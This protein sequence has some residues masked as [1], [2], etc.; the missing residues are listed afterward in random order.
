MRSSSW[1]A[2]G[3]GNILRRL[4]LQLRN[5]SGLSSSKPAPVSRLARWLLVTMLPVAVA[6][7]VVAPVVLL[8]LQ[9]LD[10]TVD[11]WTQLWNTTLPSMI[12][13]TFFLMVGVGLITFVIGSGLAWLLTVYRFPGHQIFD[14]ALVLPLAVP[15]YVMG[16][17]YMAT[18]DFAGPVQTTLRAWLGPD[19]VF[20]NIRSGGG[21]IL[22]MGLTLYPYVY[23]LARTAFREQ[24]RSTF[25]AARAMGYSRT[26]TFLKLV[27]PLA[28][29]SLVAGV[30]LAVLEA[31]TDFAT[32]RFFNFPTISEGVV[33]VWQGMMNRDA[34]IE[35]AAVFLLFALVLVMLE[36]ALRGRSRYYQ[37]GSREG[38][39]S[40]II[41]VVLHGWQRWAA[42]GLCSIIFAAAFVLPATRLLLWTVGDL[43]QTA[44]ATALRTV[45]AG[46]VLRTFGLAAAAALVAVGLAL[47]LAQGARI[48]KRKLGRGIARLA[49]MG[50]ALPGAVIAAGVLV[51]LA[52]VE[53][54]AATTANWL[55]LNLNLVLTGSVI[56]LIYAYVVRF[57]SV[58]YNSVESSLDKV[59]PQMDMA[60]R[61]LG[62]T[63]GRV[64]W[65]VHLPLVKVGLAAGAALVFVDVMKEL[66]ATILL[67]P[68]GM[69]TLSVWTYML[70]A[71]SLWQSAAL[72]SLTIVLVVII[73]VMMLMR[74]GR[75][76]TAEGT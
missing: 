16:F 58:A 70:A 5:L 57:M 49:T 9:L 25:D 36:R 43:S 50:Y 76:T 2:P 31:M 41:P 53:R 75:M 61:T 8:L 13:N 71:E 51:T 29:P 17:V 66:P 15:T 72:P 60:A 1:S 10:P 18:F 69:E 55:G 74:V 11:I 64:L 21:A 26:Q 38:R 28:R 40:R 23:F 59:T 4:Q 22:V 3:P 62:A 14:W 73:P 39:G 63:P 44:T 37:H 27:L 45:Y 54:T 46:Y 30:T 48:N 35:L 52:A 47:L 24:S 20:P 42:T 34:A 65:R 6:V 56:A 12:R 68:F 67:M 33:H 7:A 32:V 19:L